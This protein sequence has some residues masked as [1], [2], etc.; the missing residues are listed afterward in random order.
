MLREMAG[1]GVLAF[2]VT[3]AVLLAMA[4]VA[5]AAGE[6][7]TSF[8]GDGKVTTDFGG[9][10]DGANSVVTD[11][12]GRIVAAGY[13]AGSGYHKF[14]QPV[15]ARYKPSGALDPAFSGDGKVTVPFD[16]GLVKAIVDSHDRVLVAG[17]IAEPHSNFAIARYRPDGT[18]DP[19]FSGDGIATIDIGGSDEADDLAIDSR[20]RIV[21]AGTRGRYEFW[22]A[23]AR[24][25]PN[26]SIDRS[27]S[28]DGKV[29]SDFVHGRWWTSLAIDGQDRIVGAGLA[30][31]YGHTGFGV[32]RYNENGTLDSSFGEVATRFGTDSDDATDVAID[33][34]GRVI[35][36]GDSAVNGVRVFA[37]AR[38]RSDGS[39]D[40]S[41]GGDGRVTTSF[42]GTNEGAEIGGIAID[43]RG[44]IVAAG[45]VEYQAFT[46]A[47]YN[48]N[49]TLDDSFGT[50][51]R[52]KTRFGASA[53][54]S[55]VT[56]YPGD[57]IV[58]AGTTSAGNFALARYIGYP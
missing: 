5:N 36:A 51:G 29:V 4:A 18:L 23:L 34:Q 31:K 32:V 49:G 21:A 20:G 22:L 19:S 13:Q 6:L 40:P 8:G 25:N 41:F 7:D 12:H 24:F 16:G 1:A 17:A 3:A 58:A 52:L 27:F 2:A 38:Y 56:N 39:L 10:N 26:G 48:P 37:L 57:R 11:S 45:H 30:S 50:G 55:S 42:G 47:R 44:K 33:S 46:F 14:P 9:S 28:G 43:S 54:A 35:A 53:S 15:I